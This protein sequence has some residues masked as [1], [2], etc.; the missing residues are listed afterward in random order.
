MFSAVWKRYE[1]LKE[2]IPVSNILEKCEP[3]YEELDGWT[4]DIS[5]IKEYKDLP[6]NVRKYIDYIEKVTKVP[7]EIVS[8]GPERNQSIFK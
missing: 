4:E 7:V 2:F 3:V 8:V 5:E 6:E 1:L